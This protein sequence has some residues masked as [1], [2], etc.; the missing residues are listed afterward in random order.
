[1][2]KLTNERAVRRYLQVRALQETV[3]RIEGSIEVVQKEIDDATDRLR[4][5]RKEKSEVMKAI[6]EA[7]KDE[8]QLPLFGELVDDLVGHG[9]PREYLP[10]PGVHQ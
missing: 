1:M 10:T 6:R 7:A 2:N 8:G 5:L 3:E 4:D 9:I